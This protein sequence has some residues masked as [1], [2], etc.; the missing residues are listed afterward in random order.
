[1]GFCWMGG[2]ILQM[3]KLTGKKFKEPEKKLNF[4]TRE[5]RQNKNKKKKNWKN[6]NREKS[7]R[8]HL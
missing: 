8:K 5:R 7:K 2:K 1:M 3:S 4:I 6:L